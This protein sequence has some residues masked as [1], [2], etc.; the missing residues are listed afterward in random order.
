MEKF[1]QFDDE[2]R[3]FDTH[4]ALARYLQFRKEHDEW[5]EVFI[6]EPSAVGIP[7]EPLFFPKYC[8]DISV[9]KNGYILKLPDIDYD[10]QECE[11]CIESN[12]LFLSFPYRDHLVIMPT[13][14]IAYD[15]IVKR[16]ADDCGTMMR[17]DS[18]ATKNILPINEKADRL[19]RDFQLYSDLCKILLRDGKISAVLSKNYAVLPADELVET[20]ERQLKKD[21]PRFLFDCAQASH[22]YLVIEYLL[23]DPEMEGSFLEA[24]RD[25]GARISELKAGIRFSTS[26]VGMGKVYA[27]LF[28]DAD[29]VRTS[30]GG[31]IELV[32][33]G[34]ATPAKFGNLI[35]GLGM[36]FKESEEQIERL[37]MMELTDAAET[38]R[39]IAAKYTF[40]PKNITEEVANELECIKDGSTAIDVYLAMNDI[41]QRHAKKQNLSPTRYINA[42]EQV[43]KLMHLPFSRIDAGESWEKI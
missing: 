27:T 32:H 39:K 1:L 40:F 29:G 15:S 31:R 2:V 8:T 13:R 7:N 22:E 43:A 35:S 17:F 25:A 10:C 4:D 12:G 9:K 11:E 23:N 16:A 19:T 26:D 38:L 34:D 24:L 21:H 30:L 3:R 42:C 28:Y 41:I 37:G 33:E 5:I 6:N 36:L 20:M 18:S 14:P